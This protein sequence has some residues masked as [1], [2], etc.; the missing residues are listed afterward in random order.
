VKKYF[1]LFSFV[2]LTT[3]TF[4]QGQPQPQGQL[5]PATLK[6]GYVDSEV[7]LEQMPEYIKAQGDL[8]QFEKMWTDTLNQM[9]QAYQKAIADYKKT[10]ATMTDKKKAEAEGKIGAQ[11][12]AIQDLNKDKFAQN[13]GEYYKRYEQL[14]KPIKEKL[15]KGIEAVAKDEGMQYIFNKPQDALL[16]PYADITFDVT[17]KVLD[18]LKRGK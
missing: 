3:L 6:I 14:L 2:F 9:T 4:G 10:A 7:I 11:E 5:P 17:Y 8:Q 12:Q 13:T 15:V 18:K 1:I 16:I